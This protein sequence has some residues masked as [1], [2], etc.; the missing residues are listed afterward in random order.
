MGYIEQFASSIIANSES[1]HY[2]T[3]MQ[4]WVYQGETIKKPNRCIC[5]H[6]I[7][8]NLVVKNK[9]NGKD[10][11][12]GNCC[13]KKFGVKREHYNKSRIEFLRF[14]W[15]KAKTKQERDFIQSLA[16]LLKEYKGLRLSQKQA[17]WL[18]HIAGVPY[19]W[20]LKDEVS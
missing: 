10:L 1:N 9:L 8:Q 16:N 5:G 2:A 20:R 14:A 6:Y 19:R 12:I 4:E 11:I 3:A 7:Q 17:Q 15:G 18:E 13:I